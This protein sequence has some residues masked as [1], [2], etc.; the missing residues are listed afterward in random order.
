MKRKLTKINKK[1]PKYFI[2]ILVFIRVY[3]FCKFI[4]FKYMVWICQ[5]NFYLFLL[6]WK[7][8][9]IFIHVKEKIENNHQSH[10]LK[11]KSSFVQH[12]VSCSCQK[13]ITW[14]QSWGNNQTNSN[15][16]SSFEISDLQKYK[17]LKVEKKGGTDLDHS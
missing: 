2:F 9:I 1:N 14:I 17:V 6:M 16:S 7:L 4:I 15:C 3:V 12:F 8:V 10:F 11:N 13:C 5:D